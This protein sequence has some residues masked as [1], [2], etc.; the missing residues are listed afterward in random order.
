MELETFKNQALE[1]F[2]KKITD[3]FFQYIEQD[4]QLLQD[5]LSTIGRES[6][7]DTVNKCLGKAVK[8]HFNLENGNENNDP[9]SK[10]IKSYT[11]HRIE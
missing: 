7:L 11:E 5:Y 6:D 8:D 10:L 1:Q 4:R 3:I 9:K 2:T